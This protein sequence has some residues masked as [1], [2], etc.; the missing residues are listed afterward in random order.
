MFSL[1]RLGF[2]I[3]ISSCTEATTFDTVILPDDGSVLTLHMTDGTVVTPQLEAGR[4]EKAQSQFVFPKILP[5]DPMI[6]RLKS[7]AKGFD[8]LDMWMD[9]P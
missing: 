2:L 5:L 4:F 9:V 8:S 3:L 7:S 1:V 6:G